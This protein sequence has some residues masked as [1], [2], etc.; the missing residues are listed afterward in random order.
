[1]RN[2][3]VFQNDLQ[4]FRAQKGAEAA[5]EAAAVNA[6]IDRGR[7]RQRATA[8]IASATIDDSAGIVGGGNCVAALEQTCGA[9]KRMPDPS[10]CFLCIGQHESTLEAPPAVRDA[11][12]HKLHTYAT[13]HTHHGTVAH[14]H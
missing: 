6:A 2:G 11:H 1:M 9:A 13:R 3:P 7:H 8:I 12:M 4:V 14:V 10:L 5:D